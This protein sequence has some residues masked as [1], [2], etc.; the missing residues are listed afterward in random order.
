MQK[1]KKYLYNRII[2][3]NSLSNLELKLI[4]WL[5]A[6][7]DERGRVQG[8]YYSSISEELDCSISGFYLTRDSLCKKGYIEWDKSYSADMDM[9]LYDNSFMTENG[10][11]EYRDYIDLNISIFND[12]EFLNSKAGA[13]RTAM[14]FIKRVAAQG[15][16]TISNSPVSIP[17][18]AEKA[19]KLWFNPYKSIC[20][21]KKLIGVT[22]RMIKE[23]IK[24]LSKWIDSA[25]VQKDGITYTV[26]TVLKKSLSN[27]R[28]GN[29]SYSEKKAY[30]QKVKTFIRR[31]NIDSTDKN[32]EDTADLIF[33]YRSK[34]KIGGLNITNILYAAISNTCSTMLNSINVH[35][36]LRNIINYNCP[37]LL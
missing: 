1:M 37:G 35:K 7:Q 24:I 9:V 29:K 20:V 25:D 32:L 15:A 14:Y 31:N 4:F 12:K 23:Y 19:R 26:F 11:V 6:H 10:E 18:E 17:S 3:D 27:I 30:I 34:A 33:Q 5:A 8:I 28:T 22:G 36:S 13:I 21:L 2:E 16:I